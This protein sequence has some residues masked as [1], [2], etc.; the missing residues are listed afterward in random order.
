M[1][2]SAVLRGM[3]VLL[4][5]V[6]TE[7]G[8]RLPPARRAQAGTTCSVQALRQRPIYIAHNV[9]ES[10]PKL[11]SRRQRKV[12]TTRQYSMALQS[13]DVKSLLC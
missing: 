1:S 7:A 13:Y 3:R 2:G 8:V 6:Q 12:V 10:C 5:G 11:F 9:F 4:Q